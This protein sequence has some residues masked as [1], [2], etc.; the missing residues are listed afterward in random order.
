MRVA[1]RLLFNKTITFMKKIVFGL[2]AATIAFTS[3]AQTTKQ[4]EKKEAKSQKKEYKTNGDFSKKLN[5]TAD[6]KKAIAAV[7][8]AIKKS[9]K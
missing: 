7:V 5:L 2:L 6:Q 1:V 3:M 9:A 8:E 4:A